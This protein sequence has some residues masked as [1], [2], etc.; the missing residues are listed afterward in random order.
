MEKKYAFFCYFLGILV[1]INNP[2]KKHLLILSS[3]PQILAE[4]KSELMDNFTV[5]IAA[6]GT[7]A[8]DA[9]ESFD[10]SAIIIYISENRE[11]AFSFFADIF[12]LSKNKHIPVIFLSD[13]NNNDD[14]LTAFSMG[15]ADYSVRRRGIT[16]ALI[17]RLQ[18]RI[19]A[20]E[21]EKILKSSNKTYLSDSK[22]SEMVLVNKTILV[23][24]DVELNRDIIAAMLSE[25]EGL[26]I[27]FAADGKETVEKFKKN[28]N[29]Y[30]LILMD[31]QMPE[32]N[33]LEATK[34]IRHLAC[35][36]ARDIPIIAATADVDEKEIKLCLEAGMNDFIE[37]PVAYDKI[38]A[39]A[40][41]HCFVNSAGSTS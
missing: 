11:K 8:V 20:S 28:P 21:C 30:S 39:A 25:I 4:M 23:A 31:V 12:H 29:L 19:Y 7:A 13:N 15:A 18:L 17:N 1:L 34:A 27:D 5:S 41:E 9:V 33:G 22:T 32:M 2:G 10:V 24:D 26:T 40:A 16:K 14:E 6:T 36:N 3:E 38:L 37:K 35:D